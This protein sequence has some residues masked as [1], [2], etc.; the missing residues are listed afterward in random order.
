ML[1]SIVNPLSE[2]ATRA[3][4]TEAGRRFLA[5]R[6][7]TATVSNHLFAIWGLLS[8]SPVVERR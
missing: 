3:P 8:S 7:A 1:S 2:P 4:Y 6:W 5:R